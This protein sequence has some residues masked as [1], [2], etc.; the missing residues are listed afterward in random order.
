MTLACPVCC[1]T[2]AGEDVE[3]RPS[4]SHLH[5]G[6]RGRGP[7]Q[8]QEG[9]CCAR[10]GGLPCYLPSQHSCSCSITRQ[11]GCWPGFS[12]RL[13]WCAAPRTALCQAPRPA[14][15]SVCCWQ[16]E[17]NPCLAYAKMVVFPWFGRLTVLRK[18]A[19]G[20]DRCNGCTAA[21][22]HT[23]VLPATALASKLMCALLN[24]HASDAD[25]TCRTYTSYSELA[26]DY[27]AEKLHPGESREPAARWHDQ[28]CHRAA[29]N[30]DHALLLTLSSDLVGVTHV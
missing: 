6:Q 2:G 21:Q 3:E 22:K 16:V 8:D 17:G 18:E 24:Q 4:V 1:S 12:M 30:I 7:D 25:G 20:G 15:E 5:G 26:A 29:G 27:T 11:F 10:R 13:R 14:A 9:I 23:D 28:R 19:A